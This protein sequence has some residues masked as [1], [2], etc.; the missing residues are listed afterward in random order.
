VEEIVVV[1]FQVFFELLIQ[2]FGSSGIQWAT[3]NDKVDKGC[4]F[5]FLHASVGGGIGWLSTVIAPQLILPYSWMRLGNL[6]VAP[7]VSGGISYGF[8][9]YAKSRGN[10]WD[11]PTHF[12]HGALFAFMFGAARLAFGEVR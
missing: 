2:L 7:L 11:P 12:L 10:D 6:L 1:I 5:V 8:A 3:G 4:L 9:T